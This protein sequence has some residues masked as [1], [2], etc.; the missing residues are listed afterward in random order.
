MNKEAKGAPGILGFMYTTF[1]NNYK[2]MD[3]YFR[4]LDTH[5]EWGTQKT[6]DVKDR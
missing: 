5:A 4:L 2:S 6:T 3:E 1:A